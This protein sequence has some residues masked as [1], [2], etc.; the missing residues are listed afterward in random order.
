M[1]SRASCPRPSWPRPTSTSV[2]GSAICLVRVAVAYEVGPTGF[3]RYRYLTAVWI[4]C[5]VVAPSKLQ[6]PAGDQVK[7]DTE[8]AAHLARFYGWRRSGRS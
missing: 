5:E 3:R 7:T 4:R 6:R 2:P 1:A 8:D